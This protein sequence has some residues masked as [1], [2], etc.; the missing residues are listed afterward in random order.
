REEYEHWLQILMMVT[1][2]V[3]LIVCANVANLMLVRGMER[4]REISLRIAL[5]AQALRLV[6]QALAESILLSLA[7]G[8][9]GLVIAFAGARLFLPFAFPP[10]S[11][12]AAIPIDAASSMPGLLFAFCVSLVAGV[13]FGIAPACVTPL[14]GPP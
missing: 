14:I 5:G 10:T 12:M 1:S 8:V 7:G 11:G 2:F 3:L 13:T 4:R 9:A 6:R